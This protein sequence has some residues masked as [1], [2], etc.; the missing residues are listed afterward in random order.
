MK[1]AQDM[2]RKRW[3]GA[4]KKE[5]IEHGKMMNDA[6]QTA[7]TPEQRSAIAKKAA[8]ARWKKGATK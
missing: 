3:K 7:M 2:A 4:T 6:R 5:R 1:A 8:E